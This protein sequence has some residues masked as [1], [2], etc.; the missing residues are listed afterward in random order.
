MKKILH[1]LILLLTT[2][3]Y[4]QKTVTVEDVV[5]PLTFKLKLDDLKSKLVLNGYGVRTKFFIS[6]Y[7]EGLYLKEISSDG[8]AILDSHNEMMVRLHLTSSLVTNKKII[9][10]IN[11]GIRKTYVGDIAP[12]QLKMDEMIAFFKE[13][14]KPDD[15]IDLIYDPN[16][17][18]IVVSLNDKVLGNVQGFDFK[19]AVFGIWLEDKPI[20]KTL[21]SRLLGL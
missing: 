13:E 16:I 6:L 20:N 14:L 9:E 15:N 17:D 2:T 7:V 5:L 21:K 18:S 11:N 8:K 19:R 1:L 10:A 4:S 12:I 3:L